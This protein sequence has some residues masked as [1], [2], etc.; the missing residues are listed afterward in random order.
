MIKFRFL[1]VVLIIVITGIVLQVFK[2]IDFTSLLG[3]KPTSAPLSADTGE[4]LSADEIPEKFKQYCIIFSGSHA[5]E[6]QLSEHLI[7]I[8][9]DTHNSYILADLDS[10]DF[11]DI[12]QNCTADDT[13]LVATEHQETITETSLAHIEEI[14]SA[15]AALSILTRSPRPVFQI[16][17]GIDSFSDIRL[18]TSTGIRFTEPFFPIMDEISFDALDTPDS[19]LDLTLSESALIIAEHPDGMPLVWQTNYGKGTVLSVNSTLFSEKVH[20][21]FLL[22]LI[23]FNDDY[24]IAGI[25][26]DAVTLIRDFPSPLP[27]G[28]NTEI[29]ANYQRDMGKFLREIWWPDINTIQQRH[30]LHFTGLISGG[31]E[32]SSSS[33]ALTSSTASI[34]EKDR[35]LIGQYSILLG[36]TGAELGI[37]GY[38]GDSFRNVSASDRQNASEQ[39][40]ELTVLKE[41]LDKTLGE[42]P[43]RTYAPSIDS[44]DAAAL[45]GVRKVFTD[46]RVLTGLYTDYASLQDG[47]ELPILEFGMDSDFAD[48]FSIPVFS[49]GYTFD[50][51]AAWASVNGIAQLGL[52]S[53]MITPTFLLNT[54]GPGERRWSKLQID[55]DEEVRK[56][57]NAFSFLE[58]KYAYE[59]AE[60]YQRDNNYRIYS[61]Q[62]GQ[63]ITITLD[64]VL[65]P[66]K[67]YFRSSSTIESLRGGIVR[68]LGRENLYLLEAREPVI[69]LQVS[70]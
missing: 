63:T 47:P 33:T 51:A 12:I 25:Q 32:S 15:G 27:Q 1:I 43:Y 55:F 70:Q 56:I 16:V 36:S 45:E 10:P 40:E 6:E 17:T 53:H 34:P 30:N 35:L 48:W 58:P 62:K 31:S 19:R 57:F 49:S 68:P 69:T 65:L 8:F 64:Q 13:L 9:T 28:M 29:F 5:D 61:T 24:G 54:L 21:G 39:A 4:I 7:Q 52:F 37:Q 42:I 46:L 18:H 2:V 50:P 26:A 3:I 66:K 59:I 38:G 60:E 22:Q 44:A 14:V 20:R 67:F 41:A 11:A 23:L